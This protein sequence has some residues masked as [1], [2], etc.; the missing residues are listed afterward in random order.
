VIAWEW[1]IPVLLLGLAGGF[2]LG[3]SGSGPARQTKKLDRELRDTRDELVHYRDQVAA[4]F[5]TTADLMNA[6]SANYAAI[7]RH[8]VQGAHEL[9][10]AQEP[11]FKTISVNESAPGEESAPAQTPLPLTVPPLH[12][13]NEKA[14][15]FTR[16][17]PALHTKG[18][19]NEATPDADVTDYVKEDPRY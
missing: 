9:C 13:P 7:H 18:W 6:M 3:W 8:L 12:L 5:S 10:S 17:A 1:L 14:I 19:Y 2:V 16:P 11:H 4:H 15:D